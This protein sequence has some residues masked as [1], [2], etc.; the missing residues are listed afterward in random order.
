M[1]HNQTKRFGAKIWIILFIVLSVIQFGTLFGVD[2]FLKPPSLQAVA[3]KTPQP[4]DVPAQKDAMAPPFNAVKSALTDDKR[5][6]AYTT[7]DDRLFIENKQQG[8]SFNQ[9]V[10]KVAYMQ[11]L[12]RSNTLLYFVQ[13]SSLKGYLLQPGGKDPVE[14]YEW[15]GTKREVKNIY[16][17][18][19]LEFFYIEMRHDQTSEVYKYKASG[20]IT[21]LPLGY[22][23]IDHIEYDPKAD[24]LF[25]S[26]VSGE[27]F[28]YR[29]DKLY[30]ADGTRV[31][32]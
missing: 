15:L 27:T 4:L 11:W 5:Y 21:K 10:G 31:Y 17:S 1:S 12:G 22:I 2:R 32:R 6:V 28:K 30:Q 26:T 16:F 7:S 24:V 18:P 3:K 19:Y 8:I 14:V 23:D 29:N 25:I 9:I 13:D 20:G